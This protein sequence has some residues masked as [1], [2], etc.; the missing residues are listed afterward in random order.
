MNARPNN[1]CDYCG[2]IE[3]TDLAT[4]LG[5]TTVNCPAYGSHLVFMTLPELLIIVSDL[6]ETGQ[7]K[8]GPKRINTIMAMPHRKVVQVIIKAWIANAAA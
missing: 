6:I 5:H 4:N 7:L 3:S 2:G 1:M 8:A